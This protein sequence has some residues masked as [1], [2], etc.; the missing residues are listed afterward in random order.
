MRICKYAVELCSR[1]SKSIPCS[2]SRAS[3]IPRATR[4]VKPCPFG[5]HYN[6]LRYFQLDSIPTSQRLTP[7]CPSF[8]LYSYLMGWMTSAWHSARSSKVIT[9]PW[10]WTRS[11]IADP[12]ATVV[13]GWRTDL[14]RS[15]L[16][17]THHDRLLRSPRRF[18]QVRG[19]S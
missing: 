17:N 3:M 15:G 12:S 11:T 19:A 7:S 1:C 16:C 18:G 4:A 5:G 9:P 10:D 14:V 6:Q 2:A 8:A 13:D